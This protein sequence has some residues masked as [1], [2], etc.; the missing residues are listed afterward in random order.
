MT[1]TARVS[2]TA[3][4]PRSYPLPNSL[5]VVGRSLAEEVIAQ[6]R[7]EEPKPWG[8]RCWPGT[9]WPRQS[10]PTHLYVRALFGVLNA[11]GTLMAVLVCGRCG[12]GRESV[13]FSALAR[14]DIRPNE[15]PQ[16]ADLRR[17]YCQRCGALGAQLHHMG[18]SQFFKD[19]DNWPTAYLC[20]SCHAE[21][22]RTI[23]NRP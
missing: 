13:A 9:G 10:H 14:H 5:P 3:S 4:D 21:W 2:G 20:Q 12:H 11:G 7:L 17:D 16:L 22:H 18:P 6:R 19:P 15:L 1:E 8:G 23:G